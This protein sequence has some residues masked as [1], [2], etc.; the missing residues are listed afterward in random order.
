MRTDLA[1]TA[2][3][4]LAR[5]VE[6]VILPIVVLA[7]TSLQRGAELMIAR[8]NT[9][10]LIAAGAFEVGR[11]H[12]PVMVAMHAAW[13]AGLWLLGWNRP[14]N[15]IWLGAFIL[16]QAARVWVLASLG[17]RWTTRI[18]FLPGARL[19]RRGPYR[20]IKH[21][22]YAVVTAEIAV[23]P[24]AFGLPAYAAVFTVLNAAMLFVRIRAENAA[25][26]TAP[27]AGS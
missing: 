20:F 15:L 14:V 5:R 1:A 8:R 16:L 7:A 4:A 19:V 10:R 11:E 12:Y 21:P 25:L 17:G 18:I 23:L 13:L 3:S 26:A 2:G 24:L 27:K 22:N 9:A 6:G